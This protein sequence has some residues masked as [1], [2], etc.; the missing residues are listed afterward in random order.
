MNP[1]RM[2]PQLD[3]DSLEQEVRLGDSATL[4]RRVRMLALVIAEGFVHVSGWATDDIHV[5][6]EL[7]VEVYR[8]RWCR[9]RAG[10]SCS[11]RREMVRRRSSVE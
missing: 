11:H 2:Q 7:H 8:Q 5:A 4:N 3:A 9:Q 6:T 1:V 10:R